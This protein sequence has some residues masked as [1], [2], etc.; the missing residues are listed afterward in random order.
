MSFFRRAHRSVSDAELDERLAGI[1]HD[2]LTPGAPQALYS[3]ARELPMTMP[4]ESR[5]RRASGAWRSLGPAGRIAASLA[6]AIV[7]A[8]GAFALVFLPR[9]IGTGSGP[10]AEPTPTPTAPSA[11]AGWKF[12]ELFGESGPAGSV[13]ANILPPA[14]AYC[15]LRRVQR[16]RR[17]RRAGQHRR[18]NERAVRSGR[19]GRYVPL[20]RGRGWGARRADGSERSV[21]ERV[22]RGDPEPIE[23]D[24][25]ELRRQHRSP[26]R[27]ARDV[28][29]ELA[30]TEYVVATDQ[31][32]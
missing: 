20:R 15:D 13:G 2:R 19:S 1:F 10:S 4:T 27:D 7:V 21:P 12:Q 11:P 16:T 22:R 32:R 6:A 25:H 18:G 30:R 24:L 23:P 14:P 29:L 3:Y 26:A 31:I 5:A 8:A 9:S 28:G 17:S